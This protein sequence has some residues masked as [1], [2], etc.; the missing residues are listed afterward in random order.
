[1]AKVRVIDN[2]ERVVFTQEEK[3]KALLNFV[4]STTDK[5]YAVINVPPEIFGAFGSFFSRNP[6]DLREHFFS[7][8]IGEIPGYRLSAEEGAENLNKLLNGYTH[9]AEALQSG[10]AKARKFFE[11]FY[12]TFGHKSI[13][14]MVWL[15]FVMNDVSQLVSQRLAYVQLAFFIE[16]STRFVK[17]P[18]NYYKDPDIMGSDFAETYTK[19]IETLLKTYNEL[20]EC[21]KKFYESEFPFEKWL[22]SQPDYVRTKSEKYKM[23]KYER[24]L[25][26]KV[27]D[28]IRFLLPQAILTNIAFTLDARSLEYLISTWK[29]HPLHEVRECAGLIEKHGKI[30]APSIIKYTEENL[31]YAEQYKKFNYQDTKPIETGVNILY[32]DPALINKL[33]ALELKRR[34]YGSF[35]TFYSKAVRMSVEEKLKFIE[36]WLEKRQIYDEWISVEETSDLPKILVE[37]ISDV[38]AIRDLRRH[39]KNDRD[40]GLL[41][42]DM[43]FSMPP[44]VEY[45]SKDSKSKF[46]SAVEQAHEAEL[47]IRRHFPFQAQY[48]IPMAAHHSLIMS[49]G[50]DQLQYM[51]YLRSTP[52]GNES[53]RGIMFDLAEKVL[54]IYPWL[55][56]YKQWPKDMS[57]YEAYKNAPF[58]RKMKMKGKN[59]KANPTFLHVRLDKTRFHT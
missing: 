13:A 57:F 6:K 49:L 44:N 36:E 22:S 47:K 39:Q 7:A 50:I 29:G 30:V 38:G 17:F 37:I 16:Q 20:F 45:Y 43:G 21:G 31:F 15:Q 5:V 40:E 53:Y 46:E 59:Q 12:G 3:E 54:K 55:V 19:T 35:E 42:L 58:I 32:C 56:G 51:I 18:N 48:V 11:T 33:V 23:R 41:T 27:L 2:E 9:P 1:M 10:L 28:D 24:E 52:E 34:S 25:Q 8:I 14:N 26:G 4:T